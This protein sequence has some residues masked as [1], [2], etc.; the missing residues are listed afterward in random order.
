[1]SQAEN[2]IPNERENPESGDL[3]PATQQGQVKPEGAGGGSG[4][5]P[6]AGLAAGAVQRVR[7]SDSLGVIAGAGFWI[8]L[9]LVIGIRIWW[10][11]RADVLLDV[12][13]LGARGSGSAVS[14][15]VS[16][17]GH[18]DPGGVVHLVV[19]DGGADQHQHSQLL[20][21]QDDGSFTGSIPGDPTPDSPVR[22][23]E[24]TATYLGEHVEDGEAQAVSGSVTAYLRAPAPPSSVLIFTLL[25]L[26]GLS[27][28]VLIIV[29]TGTLTRGKARS[30]FAV[31]YFM[32]FVSVVV[33]LV[34]VI[35]VPESPYLTDLMSRAPL[36]L[37]RATAPPGIPDEQWLLNIGGAVGAAPPVVAEQGD[38]NG[39][40]QPA[41][42]PASAP[43]GAPAASAPAGEPN[44]ETV[45]PASAHTVVTGGLAIPFYVIM[46]SLFGAA[47][48]I[49]RRVP[50][51]QKDSVVRHLPGDEDVSV[52]EAFVRAPAAVFATPHTYQNDKQAEGA[53][54]IRESAIKE[55][56]YLLSA[57]FLAVAVYYLL[58]VS[59][60]EI[61]TP[62]LV[63]MAFATGLTS[64]RITLAIR[65]FA[66]GRL[67]EARKGGAGGD[68]TPKQ[69][70]PKPESGAAAKASAKAP[71]A[72]ATQGA[73]AA[74]P[75]STPP[76]SPP[77]AS[78][79]A[80]TTEADPKEG[81]SSDTS[82]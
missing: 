13:T 18:Q 69:G 40:P 37:V 11:E 27:A 22:S 28:V 2:E 33:P 75:T 38:Q 29:F 41:P 53:A 81:G 32:T 74:T 72:V 66:R 39:P 46:L 10:G 59:A 9:M 44:G 5:P 57:P 63:V 79:T 67:P 76:A 23:V 77:A 54:E 21:R 8:V 45:A 65:N 16:H 78:G 50:E 7:S 61:S 12:S 26:G 34:S 49:T 51:I 31:M 70:G 80:S 19:R 47:I 4:K 56:M 73:G 14:V 82:G 1:M 58:Q 6:G 3:S 24:V 30:L 25:G 60:D 17:D 52:M 43:R 35:A 36:G 71:G 15:T 64:D 42:S 62:V 20:T 55:F 48:N 68:G